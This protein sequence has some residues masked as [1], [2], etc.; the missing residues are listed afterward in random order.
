MNTTTTNNYSDYPGIMPGTI[1]T[2][3]S[4]TTIVVSTVVKLLY[5]TATHRMA[6]HR[7]VII[8][9]TIITQDQAPDNNDIRRIWMQIMELKHLHTH[10]VEGTYRL[11]SLVGVLC[12]VVGID[13]IDED[14][15]RW[16]GWNRF[17][18]RQQQP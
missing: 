14:W 16:G 5:P 6:T 1:D 10:G 17:W 2:S 13:G 18:I 3:Y 4:N 7:T 8:P 11:S 9:A 15:R 12:R